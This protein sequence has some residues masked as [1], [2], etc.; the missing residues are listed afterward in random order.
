MFF[1]HG[2][3]LL[4]KSC[5]VNAGPGSFTNAKRAAQV[6]SLYHVFSKITSSDRRTSA[7]QMPQK[8]IKLQDRDTALLRGLFECRVMSSEHAGALYFDGKP[9]ATK[10]RLQK[11][12]A[13]G[14]IAERPRRSFE[15]SVLF[16]TRKGLVLLQEQGVLA[17]YPAFDL[18]VL[19]RR[20]RVSDLT[21]RHELEVMDVKTAFHAA[22]TKL[23][24]FT[25]AEFS[26][27]PL[28]H[29]FTASRD[30]YGG[31]ETPVKPDGFIRLHERASD[32]G[33]FEHTFFLEV[34]RSSESQDKLVAKAVSYFEYFKSGGFA[35]RNGGTRE[36][37]KQFPF[38]LLMVFKTA[39]RRNNTAERLLQN[40]P[41]ILT[42]V[43][44]TTF[45]EVTNDPLGTIWIRPTDYRDVSRG[46]QF[47][48]E[49]PAN[50]FGY[51][52]N[53]ERE[54]F[55]ASKIGKQRLLES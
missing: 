52:R 7:P 36:D 48:T 40:T 51:R 17:E 20:A 10:K 41:P 43:W 49:R 44:M 39:E 38:R 24:T 22:L 45:A 55:I 37:F 42:M 31:A 25:M 30:A 3:L 11:L 26:T 5:A 53:G 1:K 16:L 28:L 15:P 8:S 6:L 21:I 34:D 50:R 12:K 14:F 2:V 9:E 54:A 27:W 23:P 13:A 32:D 4:R 35:V 19:E 46:T 18:P 29:E 33:K 47:D